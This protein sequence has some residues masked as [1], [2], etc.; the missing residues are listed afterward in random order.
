MEWN[1]TRELAELQAR[2]WGLRFE[3]TEYRNRDGET[4]D[5]LEYVRRRKKWMDPSNRY[6]TSEFKRGPGLRLITA[7][8]REDPG[9]TLNVF[10]FR[11][12]ESGARA[13]RPGYAVN[14]RATRQSRSV[15]DWLPIHHLDEKEYGA[16]STILAFP[17]IGP[18]I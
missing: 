8:N 16:G 18:M 2:H 4:L 3:I 10:G 12:E 7:L 15:F 9:D 5:L 14:A 6:C 11:A 17:I 1:G 13:R